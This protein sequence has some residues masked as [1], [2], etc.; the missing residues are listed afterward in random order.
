MSPL[1]FVAEENITKTPKNL[2]NQFN[3]YKHRTK[4][5][6][7]QIIH[8]KLEFQIISVSNL[9]VRYLHNSYVF[10]NG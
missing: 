8:E 3:G 7:C 9:I 2:Y 6:Y 5:V 1:F 4:I 10:M